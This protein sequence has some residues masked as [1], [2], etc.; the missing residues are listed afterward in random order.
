[1]NKTNK[2]LLPEVVIIRITLIVFLVLYHSL[3]PY[4]GAWSQ[5]YN[6][7]ASPLLHDIGI[8]TY[9]FF[10]QAFVF[11]SGYIFGMQSIRQPETLKIS[12]I[13]KSKFKRLLLPSIIFSVIYYIIFFEIKDSL[14]SMVYNIIIGVGHLWFLPML[15][16]CFLGISIIEKIKL[17]K[18]IIACLTLLA[19]IFYINLPLRIGESACYFFFFYLGYGITTNTFPIKRLLTNYCVLIFAIIYVLGCIYQLY[20]SNYPSTNL[21]SSILFRFIRITTACSAILVILYIGYLFNIKK[22]KI[23]NCGIIVSSFCFGIYIF[24]QFILKF[25]Y[26]KIP[27]IYL[28]NTKLLPFI[29]FV[30]TFIISMMLTYIF[31]KTKIGKTLIG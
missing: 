11:I 29:Y 3:A 23:P 25:L 21:L 8:I 22:K 24:H 27:L 17:N 10:L 9:T 30:I 5:L 15:F 4:C 6:Q 12:Y 28:N 31:L 14:F 19:A 7:H 18:Y 2:K 16:W 20:M 13:I 26:Y 1:M